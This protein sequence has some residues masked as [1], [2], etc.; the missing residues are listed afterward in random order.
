MKEKIILSFL[1]LLASAGLFFSVSYTPRTLVAIPEIKEESPEKELSIVPF[2]IIEATT[3]RE[4]VIA[5]TSQKNTETQ[6]RKEDQKISITSSIPVTIPQSIP[7][8]QFVIPGTT[9]SP[10]ASSTPTQEPPVEQPIDPQSIVGIVCD[11]SYSY[12]YPT[13][14]QIITD[15]T[16]QKGSGVIIDP[17]GYVITNRHV[18]ERGDEIANL[19]V[20]GQTYQ[21][22]LKF[23]PI[24]CRAGRVPEG[25]VLPDKQEILSFNPTTKVPVLAYRL[26]TIYERHPLGLTSAEA[27]IADFA[28]L[29][30]V[31][32]TDE[33][34]SFG[35]TSLPASFKYAHLLP[36]KNLTIPNKEV[37]T[38]GFPGDVTEGKQSDF[39]TLYFTGSVGRITD[40]V[41]GE[42]YY[43][44]TPLSVVTKMEIYHGRSGSPLFWRG[45]VIGLVTALD[46]NNR[47]N[48][49]SVSSDAI[50]QG[51]SPYL[52]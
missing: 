29:K 16:S 7:T 28:L 49:Y 6:Q 13:T 47:T 30:I 9:S 41:D 45:Y 19:T 44:N 50:L 46:V 1:V 43:K 14:G 31:G 34:P 5:S 27:F 2:A 18:L 35:I 39:E 26:Q 38:Y 15:K 52:R 4:E 8:I 23:Q 33:A 32:L 21:V 11:Y 17:R 22:T 12:M 36:L 25:T 3:T 40:I 10:I 24:G 42:S 37:F 48:S 51:I 20:N